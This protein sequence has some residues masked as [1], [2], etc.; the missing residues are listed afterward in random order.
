MDTET[1]VKRTLEE[2]FKLHVEKIPESDKR[3]PDFLV[4]DGTNEYLVEVKEKEANPAFGEAREEAFSRGE[5]FEVSESLATKSVLQNVVRDGRRQI[6]AHVTDESTFRIVWVH[7]TGLAYDATLE[8]IIAGLYGSETIVD[9]SSDDAFAGTCYYFG[10]SQFFKYRDSID[11]VMV[12]GR[13]GEATLCINNHSPRYEQLNA[14]VL[15]QSMPVGVRDPIRE[16]KE[17]C[18]FVVDGEVDRS[19]P[20]EVLSYLREK[21]K[22]EKL[23]VM[24]MR[25]MELHMAVPIKKV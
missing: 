7:C 16:E 12:T 6:K 2:H 25:H 1:L 9:F 15:V 3:T 21:Y 17:G 19:K 24:T 10:F 8:R 14:S 20:N 13:K 22:T 18:A 23:N 4:R 5:I 11:A